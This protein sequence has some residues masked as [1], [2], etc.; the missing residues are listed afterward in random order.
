L[1]QNSPNYDGISA[2]TGSISVDPLFVDPDGSDNILGGLYGKDDSFYLMQ[3]SAGQA[4]TSLCVNAGSDLAS[5]LGLDQKTTRTDKVGDSQIVDLGFHY[6]LESTPSL[7]SPPDPFG[8]VIP[9]TDFHLLL[10]KRCSGIEA[11]VGKDASDNKIYKY[12]KDH[13]TDD[14]GFL[15]V[16]GLENG[17]YDFFDFSASGEDLDLIISYPS[18]MPINLAPGV[19]TTVKLGLRAEGTLLVRILDASTSEPIFSAEVRVHDTG[20]DRIQLTDQKGEAYFIP[21]KKNEWYT[22]EAKAPGYATSTDSVFV[23][24]HEEKELKLSKE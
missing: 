23:V 16:S 11:I 15:E 18:L 22:I 19:T 9:H 10:E 13:Q 17:T 5:N 3:E 20:Y 14:N 4:T 8:A 7:P 12:S 24:G 21:L 2:G 6:S 1:W